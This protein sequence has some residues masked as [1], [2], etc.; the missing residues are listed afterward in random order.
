MNRVFACAI[1]LAAASIA[2][3]SMAAPPIPD[4]WFFSG[5]DRPAALKSLEGKPAPKLETDAWIGEAVDLASTK[6]KV[7]VID[8][9]ATWCGPCMRAIPEN[10]ELVAE[11]GAAAGGDLVFIGVHDSNS[12]WN[13]APD[14]VRDQKINYPV[15]VDR[16]GGPSTKNFNLQFWPTYIVIDREGVVRA[17]GLIPS[18]VR[19]VVEMLLAESAPADSGG[20]GLAAENFLG[21][22]DRP[23]SLRQREG[24]PL[25][26]IAASS[27]SGDAVT[28]ESLRGVPVVLHFTRPGG[29]LSASE[30]AAIT[31]LRER[32]P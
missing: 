23:T 20:S 9:W 12:G 10:V 17:A 16:S 1:V 4:E 29:S 32:L 19:E 15:T 3:P 5:K 26:P 7:V 13:R 21:S 25:P 6:G 22:R 28:A 18:H 24:R 11:H 2:A 14:V 30:L 31:E 8:F 27:W